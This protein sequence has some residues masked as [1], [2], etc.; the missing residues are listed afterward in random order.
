MSHQRG[1]M[2]HEFKN[3]MNLFNFQEIFMKTILSVV[4][5]LLSSSLMAQGDNS[6][7]DYYAKETVVFA[8]LNDL[9]YVSV[10]RSKEGRYALVEQTGSRVELLNAEAFEDSK[11]NPSLNLTIV[12]NDYILWLDQALNKGFET[13]GKVKRAFFSREVLSIKIENRMS[14]NAFDKED[15]KE[16]RG[17]LRQYPLHFGSRAKIQ[18][19]RSPITCYLNGENYFVCEH[20]LR[21]T[22]K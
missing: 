14:E 12:S 3:P 19:T 13:S 9:E 5:L 22:V 8:K 18:M 17:L 20:E 1:S 4:C 6:R 21:A 16:I 2:G 7:F 10:K 15:E 11:L